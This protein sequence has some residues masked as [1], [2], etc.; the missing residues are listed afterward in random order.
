MISEPIMSLEH[1]VAILIKSSMMMQAV[2]SIA[3]QRQSGQI[4]CMQK[5]SSG[6]GKYSLVTT[7][8]KSSVVVVNS[9]GLL[10]GPP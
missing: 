10:E 9:V 5:T 3:L 2:Y 6:S 8:S 1:L 7:D 4:S